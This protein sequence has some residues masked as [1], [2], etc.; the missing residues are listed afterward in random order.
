M[1]ARKSSAV[2]KE[3]SGIGGKL[4]WLVT[5]IVLPLA[6]VYGV[7]WWRVDAGVSKVFDSLKTFTQA[8][9]GSS[10]FGLNGD[11]GVNRVRIEAPPG[12]PVPLSLAIE[13]VTVHTP[14]LWWLIRSSLFGVEE[15]FPTRLGATFDN[16]D[17]SGMPLEMQADNLVGNYSGAPFEA[18][19]CGSRVAWDRGDLR[20]LGVPPA[21]S[22]MVLRLNRLGA[23]AVEFVLSAGT[24]GAGFAEGVVTLTAPGMETNP[25]ALAAATLT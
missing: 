11:V 15:K 3:S 6:I 19:G 18:E 17:L 4:V 1:A 2:K 14:G 5:R 20:T 10:F 8:S 23:D 9:R 25:A 16:F 24:P 12:S 13:R 22:K 21:H 7:I